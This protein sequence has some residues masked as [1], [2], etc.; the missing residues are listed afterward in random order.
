MS[1]ER[2]NSLGVLRYAVENRKQVRAVIRSLPRVF[3]P[4]IIGIRGLHWHAVVWQ[5]DGYSSIGDL[6]NWRRFEIDEIKNL[7]VV[8]GPWHR[9]FKRTRDPKRFEFDAVDAIADVEH[10]GNVRAVSSGLLSWTGDPPRCDLPN[11]ERRG[12]FAPF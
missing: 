4:H 8:D 11:F 6:P 10:L 7:E 9:G 3:C 2:S 1:T 12:A 5:F